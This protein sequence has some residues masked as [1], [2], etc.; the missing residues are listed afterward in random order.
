MCGIAGFISK[1]FKDNKEHQIKEMIS[2]ID[3]RGPDS[4][5]IFVDDEIAFGHTRLSILDLSYS[6]HQPMFSESKEIVIV[7]NG[8]VYNFQEL[9]NELFKS[10]RS[11]TSATDTEVIINGYLEWGDEIFKKLNGIFAIAIWDFKNETLLLSRDRFGVKPLYYELNEGELSFGSEIKTLLFRNKKER[12]I[13]RQGLHEFLFYGNALCTKTLFQGIENLDPGTFVKFKKGELSKH[14]FWSADMITQI[15]CS[16]EEAKVKTQ[17]LLESAVKRQLVGDV[18]LGVFLSGGIDSSC[19]TAFAAKHYPSKIKTF[20][21]SFDFDKG[22]NEL[23]KSRF[24]SDYYG[25]D[26]EELHIKGENLPDVVTDLVW[27]HDSPFSDAANIPLY[28]LCDQVKSTHKVI[29][30]GD[31][32]DEIFAG[33]RRHQVLNQFSKY[34]PLILAGKISS[35]FPFKN[36]T[37]DRIERMADALGSRGDGER[38]ALLLT[39]E[40]LKKSP[41]KILS[42]EYRAALNETDPF[43]EYKKVAER[44]E[45]MDKVQKMLYTDTQIILPSIFLEKV[46]KSTMA[47]SIEVRVPLLDNEL[48]EYV[49]SLPSS[50][51]VKNDEKKWLIRS[52]L[53]GIVPDN[54]LDAPKTGFG[55]PF[56]NWLKGPLKE[57]MKDSLFSSKIKDL[58][59]FNENVLESLIKDHESGKANNGFILWKM[60]NLSIWLE[61]YN[62]SL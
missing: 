41:V 26:H 49:M 2:L 27:H 61:K 16:F 12:K 29:L 32:G 7:F 55:V 59:V 33:Y 25:T 38:M 47:Q 20:S 21:A 28:L 53:R 17:N 11:F 9:K 18:P 52:A 34:Y 5:G 57:L 51:K 62:V 44:F 24:V 60:M 8:E 48:T 36:I 30:Q 58:G 15:D 3:Y 37:K 54:I 50:L 42:D 1:G 19:I 46:D 43:L 31:G 40:S 45:S 10:G 22:V 6:G 56:E 14:T 23:D 13:N 39:V 35:L 4:N